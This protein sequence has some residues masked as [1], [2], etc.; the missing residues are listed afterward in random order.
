MGIHKCGQDTSLSQLYIKS[1]CTRVPRADGYVSRLLD[2]LS[3]V[4]T[5]CT[6]ERRYVIKYDLMG[7]DLRHAVMVWILGY[8]GLELSV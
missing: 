4:V 1:L 8:E 7:M 6:S 2:S 5:V 3:F